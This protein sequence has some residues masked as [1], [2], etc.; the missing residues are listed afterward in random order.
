MLKEL[1]QR[2]FE[3]HGVDEEGYAD[4]I[5]RETGVVETFEE[6]NPRLNLHDWYEKHSWVLS[7][8]RIAVLKAQSDDDN[9]II[10]LC[11]LAEG[12][13]VIRHLF[14]KIIYLAV[15]E[16]TVR[17]RINSRTDN[18]FGQTE[19]EMKIILDWLRDNDSKYQE[20][21]TTVIDASEPL[22]NVVDEILLAV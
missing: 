7:K 22:S 21:A 9:D 13:N 11:G 19:S 6:D 10:F 5:N 2:G 4:W 3:A 1:E 17:L 12:D 14:Q 8:E 20:N 18:S 16:A 15:D